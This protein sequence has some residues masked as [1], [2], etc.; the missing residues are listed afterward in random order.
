MLMLSAVP[1]AAAAPDAPIAPTAAVASATSADVT[2]AIPAENGDAIT[3][4]TVTSDPDGLTAVGG[5]A[6]TTATVTGL[7]PGTAYT[8]TVVANSTTGGDSGPSPASNSVTPD[9]APDAPA[10]PTVAAGTTPDDEVDVTWVI[11]ATTGTAI[12]GFTVTS[13]PG[14]LTATAGPTATTATVSGLDP[15]TPYTFTVVAESAGGDSAGSPASASITTDATPTAPGTPA[16]PTST[17]TSTTSVSLTWVAPAANGSAI[18]DYVITVSPG[19]TTQ[20]SG[21][22][23]THT[24]TGLN[25]ATS[26]TFTVAATNG[27]GTGT[28]SAAS[29]TFATDATGPG[30]PGTPTASL[31]SITSASLSWSAAAAN[32]SAI[33]HYVVT[34]SPGGATQNSAGAATSLTFTGLTTGTDYTFTVQAVNGVG[35]GSASSASNSV[36]PAG[37]PGTPGDPTASVASSTSVALTWS[38]ATANGESVSYEVTATPGGATRTTT[39][40][41]LTFNSL[42]PGTSYTF[43]VEA[44]NAV[45]DGGTSGAS[46]AVIPSAIPA[47]P[48][49]P[50]VVL[51]PDFNNA[52]VVTWAAPAANGSAI[53]GYEITVNPGNHT[54][55]AGAGDTSVEVGSLDPGDYTATVVATNAIGS[56]AASAASGTVSVPDV[57]G[58]VTNIKGEVTAK[59]AAPTAFG[60][61]SNITWD[62]PTNNGGLVV[63]GYTIRLIGVAGTN[64]SPIEATFGA[65]A[66]SAQIG[67]LP[68]GTY[69][70]E[71][72]AIT[73]VGPGPTLKSN[74][75]T[76]RSKEGFI[77]QQYLDFLG[78]S[79][80][81]AGLAYWLT[82]TADDEENVAD[83]IVRFM[84]SQEFAPSRSVARLYLAYF[85]R[86]PDLEGFDFW[87]RLLAANQGTIDTVSQSFAT[88]SE[89]NT[90]YGNLNDTDFVKLVYKNVLHRDGEA[91]GVTY[92]VGRLDAGL[93]RG[94]MMT[95]FSESPENIS[96][97]SAR[98]D[99]IVTYRGMLDRRPDDEGRTFW[100]SAIEGDPA[101]LYTLVAGFYNSAEYR[102]RV[103]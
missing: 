36:T 20:N 77:E 91:E 43:A 2:W 72:N 98:V 39:N 94:A 44:S 67:P 63:T 9:A 96:A 102:A 95:S 31:A 85:E 87:Y 4:F 81:P 34:A 55:A 93:S 13:S 76:V 26:Y 23:T 28:A 37:V 29:A 8:F 32:G 88:S 86:D 24:F 1:V 27:V 90:K 74:Q 10:Q 17:G 84:R 51:S 21:G 59:G 18:T 66:L 45:G 25:V 97:T 99:V 103:S 15:S 79:S 40:T 78:R 3:G 52:V 68:N 33:T 6:A 64:V 47:T 46:N 70:A 41:S 56:S 14:G 50:T 80:D 73:A 69:E 75:F 16:A 38:A 92:W 89:F 19:G 61:F 57:P 11:P 48:A 5:A 42:T 53:T 60:R 62:P 58:Q 49:A 65:E 83:I 101:A 35:T 71:I 22:A 12:T 7:T 100:V 30:T 54:A 82:Q